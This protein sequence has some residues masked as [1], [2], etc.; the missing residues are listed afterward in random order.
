MEVLAALAL[1]AGVVV[2]AWSVHVPELAGEKLA[3]PGERPEMVRTGR[4][5]CGELMREVG[6]LDVQRPRTDDAS[7]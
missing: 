5:E 4:M 1:V 6:Q 2:A 7:R 3:E